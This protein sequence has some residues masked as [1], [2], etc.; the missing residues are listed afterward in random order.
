MCEVL[1]GS[2]EWLYIG[3]VVVDDDVIWRWK[4]VLPRLNI[5]CMISQ[6][7]G[8]LGP[9]V[10]TWLMNAVN[11][12]VVGPPI[13]IDGVRTIAVLKLVPRRDI[14]LATPGIGFAHNLSRSFCLNQMTR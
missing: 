3:G 11:S 13:V 10:Y 8:G 2:I 9:P 4:K 5:R 12:S 1:H 6:Q 7:V 14:Y